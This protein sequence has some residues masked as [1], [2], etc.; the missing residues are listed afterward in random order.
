MAGFR[1]KDKNSLPRGYD[2]N[3]IWTREMT[4]RNINNMD[5]WITWTLLMQEPPLISYVRPE[6]WLKLFMS[7]P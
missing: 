1:N 7:M 4:P 3:S 6:K 2:L 5:N